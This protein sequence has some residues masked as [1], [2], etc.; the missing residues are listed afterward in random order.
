MKT[1]MFTRLFKHNSE[2]GGRLQPRRTAA[3]W[4]SEEEE[5]EE[6][7]GRGVLQVREDKDP[8]NL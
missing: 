5:E 2:E 8:E 4:Q 6:E 3:L 1:D 7:E